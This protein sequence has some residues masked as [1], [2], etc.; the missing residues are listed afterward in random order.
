MTPAQAKLATLSVRTAREE[1]GG[2]AWY[3]I[4]GNTIGVLSRI[5]GRGTTHLVRFTRRQLEQILTIMKLCEQ[6]KRR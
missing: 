3:Y 2:E 5:E 1:N 6:E 4:E